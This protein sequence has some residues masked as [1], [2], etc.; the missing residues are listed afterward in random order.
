MIKGLITHLLL[1]VCPM[2]QKGPQRS[3]FVIL[4]VLLSNGRKKLTGLMD[5]LK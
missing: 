3:K 2:C 1:N 4:V 5:L